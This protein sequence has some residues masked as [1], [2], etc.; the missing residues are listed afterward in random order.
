MNVLTRVATV[1]V[2]MLT[3]GAT[4]TILSLF[5][6]SPEAV[7][8]GLLWFA[9]LTFVTSAGGLAALFFT[10]SEQRKLTKAET[11][12]YLQ[13]EEAHLYP[14]GAGTYQLRV[15]IRNVG[16]TPATNLAGGV[17]FLYVPARADDGTIATGSIKETCRIE[18][19]DIGAGLTKVGVASG[20]DQAIFMHLPTV[21]TKQDLIGS[22]MTRP[23]LVIVQGSIRYRD[24]YGDEGHAHIQ[25]HTFSVTSS[26]TALKQGPG[27]YGV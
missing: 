17:E 21:I 4:A 11:R 1:V 27:W 24:V 15:T 13:A 26:A 18:V 25:M 12:A 22:E 3:V 9:G 19:P 7:D 16:Q 8:Q 14:E 6:G 5:Q 2:G 20:I 10:F 23:H